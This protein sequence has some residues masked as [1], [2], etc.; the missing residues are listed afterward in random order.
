M[1]AARGAAAD[2]VADAAGFERHAHV[3]A[4]EQAR[5]AD[6]VVVDQP[7]ESHLAAQQLASAVARELQK[8]AEREQ[9]VVGQVGAAQAAR[10]T[11]AELQRMRLVRHRAIEVGRKPGVVVGRT[12]LL[13]RRVD[14][15]VARITFA[16]EAQVVERVQPHTGLDRAHLGR[17]HEDRTRDE[18]GVVQQL[19]PA[20]HEA[21]PRFAEG[22]ERHAQI[23]PGAIGG[24]AVTGQPR[25]VQVQVERVTR[26]LCVQG[27]EHPLRCRE[28]LV[29][30]GGEAVVVAD[31][32]VVAPLGT[33]AVEP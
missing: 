11:Q 26:G 16:R 2:R 1:R 7:A 21:D 9:F 28:R 6:A 13:A 32:Q 3:G 24:T 4:V 5:C 8:A 18:A 23:N 19:Q 25:T 22:T 17:L 29:V 30:L 20:A 12:Q 33:Q 15:H 14:L 27:E 31:L 10:S